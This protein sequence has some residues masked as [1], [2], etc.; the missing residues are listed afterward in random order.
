M[1]KHAFNIMLLTSLALSLP[2]AAS[3]ATAPESPE[4]YSSQLPKIKAREPEPVSLLLTG[5]IM[6]GRYIAILRER[7]GGDFPFTHMPELLAQAESDLND[8]LELVIGNLEGPISDSPYQNPG[9]AMRFNFKPETAQLLAKAGFT[10]LQTA[11]NHSLDQGQDYFLQTFDYLSQ[12]NIRGFGHADTPTG[13]HSYITYEFEDLTL[14]LLGLNHTL[15]NQL[16]QEQIAKLIASYDSQVDFLLV[17]IHWGYEYESTAR[18]NLTDFA[19]QMVDAGADFIWGHHPHVIQNS[20]VYKNAPIYYSLGNFVFDQYWSQKTQEG[21]VLA[22]RIQK[23][24]PVAVLE[25][26]VD[27]VNQGEPKLRDY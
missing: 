26:T 2:F 14:G 1:I 19:H 17:G 5:D 16:D 12:E 23:D 8:E 22:V 9:T 7:N 3:V 21:L 27:L 13:E 18:Q 6:L 24:D 25:Y 11:N 10:T 20:E 15:H 4:I